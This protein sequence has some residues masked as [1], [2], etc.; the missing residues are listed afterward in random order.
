MTLLHKLPAKR[1]FKPNS[2]LFGNTLNTRTL[3]SFKGFDN[4][5]PLR[6]I[7]V[8]CFPSPFIPFCFFWGVGICQHLSLFTDRLVT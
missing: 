5:E 4:Q 2:C 8:A 6:P 7:S 3:I 1:E